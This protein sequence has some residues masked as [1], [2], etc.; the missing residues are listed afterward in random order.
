MNAWSE[1]TDDEYAAIW[2]RFYAD[3]NF[4]PDYHERSKPAIYEPRPF[5]TFDLAVSLS[6]E[7][8]TEIDNL[9]L[10]SF[11]AITPVG[12]L[13]YSLDWHHTCYRFDPQTADRTGPIGWYPNGDYYIFLA[14]DLSFGT[15]GHPW[16][17]SICVFGASLLG[18]TER[19]LREILRVLRESAS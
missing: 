18:L 15:F 16:Q 19:P 7:T 4:K 10:D 13:M 17:E 9:L 2:D 3:F 14:D 12:R 8:S 5:V 11:R 6:D 1:L